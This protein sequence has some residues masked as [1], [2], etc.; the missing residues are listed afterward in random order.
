LTSEIQPVSTSQN[1]SIKGMHWAKEM[2][3]WLRAC[4]ALPEDLSSVPSTHVGWLKAACNSRFRAPDIAFCPLKR[5]ENMPGRVTL[6][7]KQT[8]KQTNKKQKN[9]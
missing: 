6:T 1:A 2:A 4:T 9:T 7:P 8:N 5:P 3:Q